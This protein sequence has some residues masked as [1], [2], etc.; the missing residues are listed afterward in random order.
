MSG[1]VWDSAGSA[2]MSGAVWDSAGSGLGGTVP[3]HLQVYGAAGS[4]QLQTLAG[5]V[6][7]LYRRRPHLLLRQPCVTPLYEVEWTAFVDNL[8]KVSGVT[9]A[10]IGPG[11][12]HAE[13]ELWLPGS[14]SGHFCRKW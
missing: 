8:R 13:P 10:N 2:V 9:D 4:D 1:A 3:V 11:E 7:L 6:D 5:C 12:P 14:G